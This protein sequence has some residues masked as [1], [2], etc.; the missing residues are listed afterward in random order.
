MKKYIIFIIICISNL[1][2]MMSQDNY[3]NDWDK[4]QSFDQEG[5]PKSALGV[6]EEIYSKAKKQ[7]NQNQT[8]K[9]LMYKAKYLLTLEEDAQLNIIKEFKSE[10]EQSDFPKRNLLENILAKLYWQYFEQNRWRFY[11]RTQTSKKVDQEDFRTWDL[12]TLFAEIH[13]YYQKS[14][15]DKALAQQTKLDRFDELLIKQKDSKKYRP[16]LYDFLAHNALRFYKTSETNITKPSYAFEIDDPKYLKEHAVFSTLKMETKDSLSLQFHALKLFQNLIQFHT[17]SKTPD[18]LTEVNIE[19]IKFVNYNATFP[20]KQAVQIGTLLIEKE[21][22]KNLE[23]STLYDYEIASVFNVQAG[24]YEAGKNEINRW[25]L[26]D[27][28]ELCEAA[29]KKFPKSR[30]ANKCT[31]IRDQI[32]HSEVALQTE[33]YVPIQTPGRLLIT[34]KNQNKLYFRA[35]KINQTQLKQLNQYYRVKDQLE[36]LQ[37]LTVNETWDAE[38][39]NEQDYQTH[40]TEVLLPALDNGQYLIVA[41]VSKDLSAKS[42]F[43]YGDLQVSNLALLENTTPEKLSFQVVDRNNGSPIANAKI[44]LKTE[45]QRRSRNTL[46]K[47]LTTDEKGQAHLTTKDYYYGVSAAVTFEKDSAY[48][49]GYY[50][51]KS[52]DPNHQEDKNRYSTF[53]FTDRSIYRPGQTVYFKGIMMSSK[54]ADEFKVLPD[55]SAYATLRDVNGQEI[56]TLNFKTNEYGSFAGEF[57]LPSSGLT[58]NYTI[59]TNNY[60]STSFSVEEYKRPK[61]E[62]NFDPVTETYKINDTIKLTGVAKAYAGSNITDAKVVYRVHRK[63]QYPHWYYWYWPGISSESQEITHGETKTN[64]KGEYKID[65]AALPDLS[66]SKK[67]LPVFNYEITADVTD[68]NGET[69]STTT[70][71]NVG[72]HALIANI[73]TSNKIDKTKNDHLL[74]V[75]TT[76]LNNESVAANG[77]IKI[78]K[79]K[80]SEKPLRIRPWKAPDY[81]GFKEEEFKKLFPHDAFGNEDDFRKWEKGKLVYDKAFNTQESK[82]NST[83]TQELKLGNIKKWK[84]GKYII[85][86]DT[87]DRFGQEVKDIQYITV[88]SQNDKTISDQQLF[89]VTTDKTSY[90]IGNEVVITFSSASK[91]ITVTVDIEKNHSIVD[92]RLIKLSE[93]SKTIKIP[94]NKEDLGGFS[95]QY[96]FV[97]YNSYQSG[98]LPISVPYA[99][100]ELSIETKTFRDKLLPGQQETWSFTIKGPKGDKVTSELLASMYDASLD[101]FK[102]HQWYFNPINRPSYYS[103]NKRQSGRS[104]ITNNFSIFNNPGRSNSYST[105]YFD[106]LNW[107]GLY[108]GN[109][110]YNYDRLGNQRRSKSAPVASAPMEMS[111]EG[112]NGDDAELEESSQLVAFSKEENKESD[113]AKDSGSQAEKTKEPSLEGVKIRKNLQETAFFF[114][115]LTTDPE[116]NVSFNFTAPEALTK[117]KLQLLTHTKDLKS[118]TTTLEAVTQK[119]LMVLPNPPRFLREGDKITLSTKVSN[120]ASKDLSGVI[121]LQL[122]DAFTGKSIDTDLKNTTARQSFEVK[123]KGNTN[124]SWD[125]AIPD[126]IQTVQYKIV[127][128]AGDFSDGEQ[129]MLP[130]LSNRMLV[131]ETLPMWIRSDQTKTFTLAKLKNNKSETLKHHKLT[132]EMTS[133][134]AWYAVQAL[135]YLMEYPYECAEQTFSRYYANSLASHIANSNPRIQEVFN[136]W[137]NT[138]ALLSNL[139]KN[140]ELKS[141][142]IQETPWLRDAQ[143]E[144]EQKKRIALLFDLNKMNNE[145]QSA[146]NK[147]KQMQYGSGA[148]PWFQGGRE[149]RFIT[150]HIVTGFGHLNKLE[151]TQNNQDT[152]NMLQNAIRYLD[153]EFVKE[154][155]K[156]KRYC[157]KNKIDINKD[158]LSYTQMHYLYMRSFF[159]DIKRSKDTDEAWNYYLGQSKKYWLKRSL[160]AQGMLSLILHRNNDTST[161]TKIIRSLDENSITSEELGMYWKSNTSSWFWYQAPIETQSLMIEVFSEIEQEPKRTEIVDNLKVWLLKNKQTNRWQTTKATSDAVYALL[162]QGSDWLSVTDMVEIVL[163]NQKIDPSQ[164]DDVKV[165]AGTGY[166]KTSWNTNEVKPEMATAK[167]TKKGKGI[168]WGALYWQYFE[169]LDKITSA[170]TPLQLKKKLFLKKNTDTGEEITEVTKDSQLQLGD[171]VRVRI[172]LRSDRAMEFVHMKDMRASGL[173]PINVISQYKW[174]DGLGYYESTKD[175]STNFFFDYLPKGI[176]VFEY[177]LRVNNK[178]DFS[179]GITTIQSMYAPEFSSHSEGVRVKVE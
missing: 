172:E 12:E 72:Y 79:L 1:N 99:P 82:N 96:S 134:P 169:D 86:L 75:A 67:D 115:Q 102:P 174:Q 22:V 65:F 21:K 131:T 84:S 49:E 11:D 138:D 18:A 73:R 25:K 158:H 121:E 127:A 71:V 80:G 32:L 151:V 145:L 54:G 44:H 129:N 112:I 83:G 104:F 78:F 35:L 159:K 130:V 149:N 61:F 110:R 100:T 91:D 120:L 178:G 88:Y 126:N 179:N 81:K 177:D 89:Q 111:A 28:L 77:N 176:Y 3:K 133:N 114:P 63:V 103:Y 123:T 118:A 46:N 162:L 14:L 36:L 166:F 30:G 29:I 66:V 150:Q 70:V 144:T 45:N 17:K 47:T 76:N 37:S 90:E 95:V 8:I 15:Q 20:N 107:Y 175:A 105:Q 156:L 125:L 85:E 69:R 39:C 140:Q 33:K 74:T 58:G 97:N 94:V 173:E 136:Q 106:Q 142:I 52:Y 170:K 148:F 40:T 19:R 13:V 163:G 157:E 26:K 122:V 154:Y 56:K 165:E 101:Q 16:T 7:N 167:I 6:V 43:S 113:K 119:E 146:I 41:T 62:T 109:I 4:V 98:I 108:F 117:W 51:N 57:I 50:L 164:I 137:K 68:I 48:F 34:Y 147:L 160:Y 31:I 128:K 59:G 171:L 93:N 141:L 155:N 92:T 24:S 60:G 152:R 135:P 27:A 143:S 9:A 168:A 161:A 153:Q 10:I 55:Q 116:G 64:D 53:L 132:L 38:I 42:M 23:V 139:E 5:L 2:Y 87:K 124:I